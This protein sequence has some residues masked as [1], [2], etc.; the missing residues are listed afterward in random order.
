[1]PNGYVW[2]SWFHA[3]KTPTRWKEDRRALEIWKSMFAHNK[4]IF[5][6]FIC[7]IERFGYGSTTS[8]ERKILAFRW[9][10]WVCGVLSFSACVCLSITDIVHTSFSLHPF[11]SLHPLSVSIINQPFYSSICS[12]DSIKIIQCYWRSV[13]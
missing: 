9:G 8:M 1:M 12:L 10:I 13:I 2:K 5:G 7:E 4:S 11:C 6:R 3:Y